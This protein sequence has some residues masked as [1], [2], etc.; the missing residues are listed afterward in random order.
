MPNGGPFCPF[1]SVELVDA[2]AQA[3]LRRLADSLSEGWVGPDHPGHILQILPPGDG[4][5]KGPHQVG[6][7]FAQELCPQHHAGLP[8]VN[9]LDEA[10][11]RVGDDAAAVAPGQVFGRF[12]RDA[13]LL[14]LGLASVRPTAAISGRT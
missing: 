5:G 14:T 7:P 8:V 13:R 4:R 11:A 3:G 2:Q 1:L 9:H 6:C 12:D 10:P